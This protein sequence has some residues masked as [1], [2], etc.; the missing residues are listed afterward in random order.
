MKRLILVLIVLLAAVA[1]SA[2]ARPRTCEDKSLVAPRSVYM[3]ARGQS[4]PC[5]ITVY[6][7]DG[8]WLIE[9]TH[10]FTL[11][12]IQGG[13][14]VWRGTHLTPRRSVIVTA[15]VKASMRCSLRVSVDDST[16]FRARFFDVTN[17]GQ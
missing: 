11:S 10:L 17:W 2:Y 9:G 15:V 14:Y 6:F 13:C 5:S 1:S 8:Y 4:A 7:E 16:R 3:I 12:D